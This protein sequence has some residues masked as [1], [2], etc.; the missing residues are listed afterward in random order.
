MTALI[1]FPLSMVLE[2]DIEIIFPREP[3]LVAWT[4]AVW[5][6]VRLGVGIHVT[7]IESQFLLFFALWPVAYLSAALLLKCSSLA[8]QEGTVQRKSASDSLRR[9]GS[10]AWTAESWW[11]LGSW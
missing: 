10:S 11:G 4:I 8:L 6:D 1:H 5:T 9:D 3:S 2:V 7:S